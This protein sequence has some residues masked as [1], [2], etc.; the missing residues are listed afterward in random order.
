MQVFTGIYEGSGDFLAGILTRGLRLSASPVSRWKVRF[1]VLG[2]LLLLTSSLTAYSQ[3][4][5]AAGVESSEFIAPATTITKTVDEVNLAFT[6]TDKRG[7]FISNLGP[8]DFRL[9]D[10]HQAPQRL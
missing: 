1:R 7:R 6:V 4:V 3:I 10:N 9:V 8:R 2:T 5:P